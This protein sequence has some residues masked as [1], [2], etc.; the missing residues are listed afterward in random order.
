M[1]PLKHGYIKSYKRTPVYCGLTLATAAPR[2]DRSMTI[3]RSDKRVVAQQPG[4]ESGYTP[5]PAIVLAT[6]QV[7]RGFS[8]EI[9]LHWLLA[10]VKPSGFLAYRQGFSSHQSHTLK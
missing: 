10:N 8:D 3:G 6:Q 2:A 4:G 1:N 7:S 5:I 9:N